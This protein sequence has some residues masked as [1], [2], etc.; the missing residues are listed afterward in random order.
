M[1]PMG[2]INQSAETL[3]CEEINSSTPPWELQVTGLRQRQNK[4]KADSV[5]QWT[6]D[7][8]DVEPPSLDD[9]TTS[10]ASETDSVASARATN[11][12]QA[13]SFLAFRLQYLIVHI[14]IMLADGMQGTR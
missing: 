8:S 4:S 13:E 11:A 2:S 5:P 3:T 6:E 14:A 9:S 7:D 1:S 12:K 10:F